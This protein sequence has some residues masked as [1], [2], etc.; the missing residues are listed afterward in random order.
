MASTATLPAA[1]APPKKPLARLAIVPA[2][3]K[4]ILVVEDEETV[5]NVLQKLLEANGFRVATAKDGLEGMK[6][7]EDNVP[8]LMLV[9]VMMPRLDGFTFV[10]AVRFRTEQQK[11][12]PKIPFIFITAKSDARS[13]IEGIKTGA[14]GFIPKP[15]PIALVVRKVCEALKLAPPDGFTPSAA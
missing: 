15:F 4:L 10:K 13:M 14:K 5:R 7:L 9:D 1:S 8:D 11:S 2:Y 12:L 3:N 6:Y